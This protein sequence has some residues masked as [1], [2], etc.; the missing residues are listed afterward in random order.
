MFKNKLP[1]AVLFLGLTSLFNDVAS[2]ILSPIMPIFLT[3][4]LGASKVFVGFYAGLAESVASFTK[5][6]SGYYSDRTGNRHKYVFIGYFISNITRPLTAFIFLPW[7]AIIL[8]FLDRFGKGVRNAPR[9]AWL[10]SLATPKNRGEVF[11]FHKMLDN[12]GGAIGPLI[13]TAL[14]ILFP[15]NYKLLFF[16]TAIP[17]MM[18][19]YF[20]FLASK[21]KE[22]EHKITFNTKSKSILPE[23]KMIVKMP[24]TFLH[25]I[26]ILCMF[27]FANSSDAFIVLKLKESGIDIKWIPLLWGANTFIKAIA[28]PKGGW[29]SDHYGRKFPILIGWTIFSFSY[30][31][32]GLTS[33]PSLMILFFMLYGLFDGLTE[34]A[35][36]ALIAD[37]IPK[38]KLGTAFGIYHL[39]IG[40]GALP[41]SLIAGMLWQNFG[42]K[43]TFFF[44]SA[45]SLICVAAIHQLKTPKE[46]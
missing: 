41:S 39:V 26:A 10:G 23:W 17:G 7:H 30:L 20:V 16:I 19:L 13:A 27:T 9:D 2:E 15:N 35:E 24:K 38:E 11:G 22:E 34:G 12:L 21:H 46:I 31:A 5:I 29:I 44:G 1:K 32:F 28:S 14:L 42:S 3:E 45:L 25:Y 6:L 36:K 4:V 40:I 37:L 43:Y 8:K 18:S 33:L